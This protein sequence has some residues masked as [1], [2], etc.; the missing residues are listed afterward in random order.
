MLNCR[1]N[2]KS[3]RIVMTT[4]NMGKT[5]QKHTTSERSLIEPGACM[6]SLI[7]VDPEA[8]KWLLFSNPDSTR[9]RHHITIKASPDRGLTWPDQNRLL[10]DEGSGGGYSC[11]SMID[12]NTIGI[13]YEGSQAHMTFQRI[14]LNDLVSK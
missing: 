5:W 10:L 12:K 6:A 2:R 13:L 11:M 1:Y 8:G 4:R 3:V 7:D 9:G 14:A